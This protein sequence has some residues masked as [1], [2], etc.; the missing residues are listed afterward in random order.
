MKRHLFFCL[1]LVTTVFLSG[2]SDHATNKLKRQMKSLAKEYL[3]SMEISDY[4]ELTIECVDT[5]TELGYAKLTTELLTNMQQAYQE[6]LGATTDDATTTE[7]LVN[8]SEISSV[9][10]EL[11]ERIDNGDLKT[12]GV[13][14]YMVTGTMVDKNK[15]KQEFMFLVNSDKKSLHNLD[16]F[17]DNLL[18]D[19]Q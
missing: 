4:D 2:C 15:D 5:L 7:L 8:L 11:E 6:Q 17:G 12:S 10:D 9:A 1:F 14:L 19:E 18:R 13:L 3:K 16:P